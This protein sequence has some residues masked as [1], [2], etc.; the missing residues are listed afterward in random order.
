M[1]L[2]FKG[3]QLVK[4]ML[5]RIINSLII[6]KW[7]RYIGVITVNVMQDSCLIAYRYVLSYQ[8]VLFRQGKTKS[9]GNSAWWWRVSLVCDPYFSK[10]SWSLWISSTKG[11]STHF[12]EKVN[13]KL[14]KEKNNWIQCSYTLF[15]KMDKIFTEQLQNKI[16]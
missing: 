10:T 16:D 3:W 7:C 15:G 8:I 1:L 13:D 2:N 6:A 14:M 9:R 4:W 11:N 5:M 12:Y